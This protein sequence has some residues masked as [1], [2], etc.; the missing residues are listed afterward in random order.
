MT[1]RVQLSENVRLLPRLIAA[2]KM[3]ASDTAELE[4]DLLELMKKTWVSTLTQEARQYGCNKVGNAP[5]LNDLSELKAFAKEDAKSITETWNRDVER[6]L[7]RLFQARPRGNRFYYLEGME[8]WS[9]NRDSWK[10][11]QIATQTEQ[12]VR[13]YAQERFWEENDLK[14]GR[15]IYGPPARVV[16]DEC[17]LR[18]AAGVVDY[19]YV[20]QHP[21]PA[22]VGCPHPWVRLA[23][24]NIPCADMWVG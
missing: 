17:K 3:K 21:A 8:V 2:F 4:R 13:F 9:S 20:K 19:E 12:R 18:R 14:N 1:D 10:S 15:F 16:S 6:Q 5:R 23:D 7:L 22:H 11:P 24:V